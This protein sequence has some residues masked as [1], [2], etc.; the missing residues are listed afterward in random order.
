MILKESKEIHIEMYHRNKMLKENKEK[1]LNTSS[2]N[3]TDHIQGNQITDFHCKEWRIAEL[4]YTKCQKQS[5][6][7]LKFRIFKY[8][9]NE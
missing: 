1:I 8:F 9:K 2:K 4:I 7:S 5:T 6:K 3:M